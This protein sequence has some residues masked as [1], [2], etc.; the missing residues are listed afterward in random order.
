VTL[1][2]CLD[3]ALRNYPRIHEAM[4]H[5][6]AKRADVDAAH[7]APYTEFYATAAL[8]AAPTRRGTAIF[9]PN[10]DAALTSHMG[11]A[12]QMGVEGTIPLWTFGKI[13][14]LWDAAEAV[15]RVGEH[16]V[17]REKNAVR[18][19][20][21]RAY[22]AA[23]AAHDS[24][25]ISDEAIERIDRYLPALEAKV[26]SGDADEI[27]LL[28]L[29]MQRAELAARQG[30]GAAREATALAGLAF[31]TGAPGRIAVS[32]EPLTR[33]KH[34][35]GPLPRYLSAARLYR[36]EVN[37]VRAGV[38]AQEAMV[39]LERARYF[40]DF[41]VLV[42]AKWARAPEVVD[43]RNPYAADSANSFGYGA[44][45]V[46]NYKLDFLPQSARVAHAQ[47]ELEAMRASEQ[48]ALGG[49]G[50]EVEEAFREAESAKWRLDAW[51]QSTGFAERWLRQVEQ[52]IAAGTF[53]EKELFEPTRELANKR[54]GKLSA[55][56]E[57]N[58]ALAKLA[59]AT[60]WEAVAGGDQ[61]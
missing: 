28:K 11:L 17:E 59:Q 51:S 4:A 30:E 8:G 20:V 1:K 43:Q 32:T 41:G 16:D 15:A 23:K 46:L 42:T 53:D 48:Y 6:R 50:V 55:I 27:D 21:R 34:E 13:T 56:F 9:S 2:R 54:L 29:R 40:P 37:M 22:Y 19:A 35:L 7:Y 57:Y 47:A 26:A 3:L 25:G 60:G 24:L 12:W 38:L 45:L 31:L 14:N 61:D 18:F 33:A 5:A 52:R 39:R 44:G 58:V 49:V 10:T 36:P